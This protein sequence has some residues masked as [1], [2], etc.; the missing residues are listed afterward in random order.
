VL[1]I[2]IAWQELRS[3]SP[4]PFVSQ[5]GERLELI[6]LAFER[7]YERRLDPVLNQKFPM[8]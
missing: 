3:W 4:T 8:N 7:Y 1:I 6:R 5:L 2:Q